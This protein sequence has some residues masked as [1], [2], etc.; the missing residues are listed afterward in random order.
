MTV[1]E[2]VEVAKKHLVEIL[3]TLSE[4]ALELEE[5]ETPP[6]GSTWR[7]TFTTMLSGVHDGTILSKVIASRRIA[8]SVEIDSQ[9]GA[10][11]A[12]RNALA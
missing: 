5:L 3:P 12:V 4:D 8:K 2:G 1:S 10:L 7:F 9:S 11:L 6:F